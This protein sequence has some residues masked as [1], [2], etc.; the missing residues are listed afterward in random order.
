[1]SSFLFDMLLILNYEALISLKSKSELVSLCHIHTDLWRYIY[2]I[3]SRD[4]SDR[5]FCLSWDLSS[6]GWNGYCFHCFDNLHLFAAWMCFDPTKQHQHRHGLSICNVIYYI[7]GQCGPHKTIPVRSVRTN[8]F[9]QP[10]QRRPN[11]RVTFTAH[12]RTSTKEMFYQYDMSVQL[13]KLY[14][15][16]FNPY[17]ANVDNMASSYQC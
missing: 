12:G 11:T 4:F 17:P 13:W 2:T 10:Q 5:Y 6:F 8:C 14:I 3:K 9:K 7:R 15:A 1:M 16:E